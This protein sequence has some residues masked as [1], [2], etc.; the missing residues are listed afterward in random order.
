MTNKFSKQI[1]AVTEILLSIPISTRA[2]FLADVVKQPCFSDSLSDF[3]SAKVKTIVCFNI[4]CS[5]Q[6]V[7]RYH[8][9]SG[10]FRGILSA[11]VST[12][13]KID[14]FAQLF[15]VD[16]RS[17]KSAL[18]LYSSVQNDLAANIHPRPFVCRAV[19]SVTR[20]QPQ[21]KKSIIDWINDN[22]VETADIKNTLQVKE[23]G[24]W[25]KRPKHYRS[26][27]ISAMF[28]ECCVSYYFSWCQPFNLPH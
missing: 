13:V 8:H 9:K 18:E 19:Y 25:I 3:Q 24:V 23:Q 10:Q 5:L 15:N 1:S 21:L 27:P 6:Q 26:K 16:W 17:V 4:S 7:A 14:Q 2:K 20:I 12:E 28:N 11:C 22:T